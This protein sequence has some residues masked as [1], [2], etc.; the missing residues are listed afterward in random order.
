VRCDSGRFASN[1]V[2][3]ACA[4]CCGKG[5]C[6]GR[7][8]VP[9]AVNR[10]GHEHGVKSAYGVATRSATPTLDPA[11]VPW[12]TGTYEK[13]GETELSWEYGARHRQWGRTSLVGSAITV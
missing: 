8:D 13:D 7:C 10:P 11:P 3:G 12:E 5:K 9:L 1:D 4:A 6:A 2:G